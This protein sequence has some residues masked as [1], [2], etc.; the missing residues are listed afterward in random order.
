MKLLKWSILFVAIVLPFFWVNQLQAREL[1]EKLQLEDRYNDMLNQAVDDAVHSLSL[2]LIPAME[3]GYEA[4]KRV[5]LNKEA[6]LASFWDTLLLY[7]DGAEDRWTKQAIAY[8]MPAFLVMGYNGIEVY[9]SD[10]YD[11]ADGEANLHHVWH[12]KQPYM[13]RDEQGMLYAFTL[14]EY[15]QIYDPISKTTERGYRRELAE[16]SMNPLLQDAERFDTLRRQTI[17]STIQSMLEST[18]ARHNAEIMRLGMQYTFTLPVIEDEEWQNTIDD[19]GV[20]AFIQGL[21][22]GRSKYNHYALGASKIM[23]RQLYYGAMRDGVK[24]AY[25]A[26][27]QPTEYEEVLFSSKQAAERGFFP[28]NCKRE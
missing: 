26:E 14:D 17:I 7:L 19:V 12:P 21:P 15:I 24:V 23:R 20:L 11:G 3:S 2:A 28:R 5:D 10:S 1:Y 6:A 8:Y 22:L 18:I 9:A 27:C 4:M 16:Q 25:P 13:Y